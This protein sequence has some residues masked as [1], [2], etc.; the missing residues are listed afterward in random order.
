MILFEHTTMAGIWDK[1]CHHGQNNILKQPGQLR[2]TACYLDS[3]FWQKHGITWP[4]VTDGI[5][6]DTKKEFTFSSPSSLARMLICDVMSA[7]AWAH[8]IRWWLKMKLPSFMENR[9]FVRVLQT[10]HEK[11]WNLKLA[12]FFYLTPGTSFH[13]YIVWLITVFT[14]EY[15][16]NIKYEAKI[17]LSVNTQFLFKVGHQM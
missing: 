14:H 1:L 11:L 4:R 13:M 17:R 7:E 8:S 16:W 3:S 5:V 15:A 10:G 6:S 12:N 2:C 9:R